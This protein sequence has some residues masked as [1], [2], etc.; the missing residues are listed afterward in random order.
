MELEAVND[1]W[2]G[3]LKEHYHGFLERLTALELAQAAAEF[4][5]F[6]ALLETHVD[7]EERI[8]DALPAARG[9]PVEKRRL[10]AADHLILR[11][12]LKKVS[13]ALTTVAA[14]AE[15]RRQLVRSL[16]EFLRLANV[17]AHHDLR[18]RQ[19]YYPRLA[20]GLTSGE[21]RELGR[22]MESAM[23]AAG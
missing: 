5:A 7:F 20:A 13:E 10:V 18:E 22:Q 6:R 9:V 1:R 8:I 16:N 21:R 11:R 23:R 12:L 3:I 14:A 2:H 17:L 15:P 19:E 4:A